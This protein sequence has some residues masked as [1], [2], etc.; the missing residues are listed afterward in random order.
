MSGAALAA[1]CLVLAPLAP[2]A[3]Q[4]KPAAPALP[5]YFE[6][7]LGQAASDALFLARA[8]GYTLA[9]GPRDLAF[10]AG[11]QSP[12]RIS[13]RGAALDARIEGL[14]PLPSYSN[15]FRGRDPG[16]WITNVPHFA[17]VRVRD[18]Y[19][20][21]D[22][23][24][25][26]VQRQVEFDFVVA[27]GAD[28]SHIELAM[29][30]GGELR[31]NAA[32]DLVAG[33]LVLRRP[34]VYQRAGGREVEIASS[35]RI[36][37]GRAGFQLARWD[38]SREL[39]I[40]PVF[41]YWATYLGGAAGDSAFSV[42]HTPNG[43]LVCGATSSN[44]FPMLS[45]FDGTASLTDAFLARF[46]HDTG[47]LQY[48]TYLG[49]AGQES[50]SA[51]AAGANG[52][53]L[54]GGSTNSTDFPMV[55][56]YD[57]ALGQ[58]FD[59]FVAR[60][61]ANGNALV[62]STYLGGDGFDTVAAVALN[63]R[64]QAYVAGSTGSSNFPTTPGALKTALGGTRDGFVVKLE[65]QGNSL[66]YSTLLG[67]GSA[68]EVA[69][70]AVD[71]AGNVYL[72]GNTQSP[73]F[74]V[75]PGTPQTALRFSPDAFVAKLNPT[76]SGL[77]Y[78]TYVGGSGPD[79][80]LGIAVDPHG[81]AYVAGETHSA[82][83]PTTPGAFDR[84][85]GGSADAFAARLSSDGSV[86]QFSSYLGGPGTDSGA[87]AASDGDGVMF[88]AGQTHGQDGFPLASG[89]EDT[90]KAGGEGFVT[91]FFPLGDR[92]LSSTYLG[93]DGD[94]FINGASSAGFE[95]YVAGTANG[96]G[97]PTV[98]APWDSSH[99]GQADAFVA[100]FT[101][102]RFCPARLSPSNTVVPAGGA[103]GQQ[104][105]PSVQVPC[106]AAVPGH[107]AVAIANPIPTAPPGT[108]ERLRFSVAAN[109]DPNPRFISIA[110]GSFRHNIAQAGTS[111][112]SYFTDVPSSHPFFLHI[113]EMRNRGITAGCAADRYCPGETVTRGQ[114]AVFLVRI[115]AGDSF[116][117]PQVQRFADVS[118]SHP[119][120]KYIQ[121][122]EQLGITSGCA[123]DRFCPDE[124]V[125]RGQMAVFIIRALT[126]DRVNPVTGAPFDDV[127]IP[128][129]Y[130]LHVAMMYEWGITT[131][132]STNPPLYG[133]DQPVTREAMAAFLMRAFSVR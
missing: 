46:S 9:L 20:G 16:K 69:G 38:R 101:W 21:V 74:P 27:P 53:I 8:A 119:Y 40:D 109:P 128:H 80:G 34:R 59:G 105:E 60:L 73:D 121:V 3:T 127:P 10:R 131:G 28:P 33:G 43:V 89:A 91:A 35:Y 124:A 82:D 65:P 15:Y 83:F 36:R 87:A 113:Q 67:G 122:M 95:L 26:G 92:L 75:T 49:G 19:P 30:G 57:S 18:A 106:W 97:L 125:T 99:N 12:V 98:Q 88:V 133:V 93:G 48:A 103:A 94:E 62:Y 7:N 37:A 45:P 114:M 13:L 32:G 72:T 112:A 63:V 104:L 77:S 78:S 23:V 129:P 132:T 29:E 84:T 1:I 115:L 14:D 17:R 107:P 11:G 41:L 5:L 55:S 44:D 86:L 31:L 51:V 108:V 25:Y 120:F 61:H 64:G 4:G 24:Y 123:S 71:G 81:R 96:P 66:V 39:V 68:D 111:A 100:R 2:A 54:L 52:D 110:T 90:V 50:C 70:M 117:F 79:L 6:P 85:Y 42:A 102:P 47:A 76:G 130:R 56:P 116:A 22:V 118:P 58:G 126:G